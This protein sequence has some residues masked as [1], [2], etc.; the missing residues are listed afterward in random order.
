MFSRLMP[1]A[2]PVMFPD[3]WDGYQASRNRIFDLLEDEKIRD[4][5]VLS[6]DIHSSWAFDVPRNPWAGYQSASGAGSLAVELITPAISSPPLYADPAIAEAGPALKE[7]L[8]HLKLLDGENRGYVLI[9][10][11]PQRLRGEWYHVPTVYQRSAEERRAA[12]FVCERG[13]SRFISD[14]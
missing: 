11:T 14:L 3:T 12:A 7:F 2:Q 5:A 6:G 4:L 9:E 13:S 1:P 8:P 10:I